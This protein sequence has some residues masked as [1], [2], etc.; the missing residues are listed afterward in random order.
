MIPLDL[1]PQNSLNS[2]ELPFGSRRIT[3]GIWYGT[4]SWSANCNADSSMTGT[5]S[6]CC[7]PSS[8]ITGA[9]PRTDGG[10]EGNGS[11]PGGRRKQQRHSNPLPER[12]PEEDDASGRLFRKAEDGAVA[13]GGTLGLR[14]GTIGARGGG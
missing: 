4:S 6:R 8:T 14:N 5:V 2:V 12:C 11:L 1:G 3:R 7:W 9:A 13:S 10:G